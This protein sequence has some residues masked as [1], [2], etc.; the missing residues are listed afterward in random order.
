MENQN[1]IRVAIVYAYVPTYHIAAIRE[2]MKS[3]RIEYDLF[4]GIDAGA[5]KLKIFRSPGGPETKGIPF[6][7]LKN[8]WLTRNIL[9][10]SGVL[11][12]ACDHRY[13]AVIYAGNAYYISTWLAAFIGRIRGQQ[14]FMKTH[15]MSFYEEGVK[16]FV[17]G[18]FYGL[19]QG[20]LLYGHRAKKFLM[21]KRFDGGQLYVTYNC[22]DYA[23][24]QKVR[25]GLSDIDDMRLRASL[26]AEPARPLLIFIGRLTK[27]KRLDLLVQATSRLYQEGFFVNVVIIG[28]GEAKDS[29][30]HEVYSLGI[31]EHFK[32]LGE[33]YDEEE[34]GRWLHASDLCVSP[35]EV[36]LNV[37]HSFAY[38]TPV[39]THGDFSYQGPEAEAI[40]LNKTGAFF[41][42]GSAN[43]L[44]E[45]IS[46]WLRHSADRE[47]IRKQCIDTVER[48]YNPKKYA[49]IIAS[50]VLGEQIEGLEEEW[51]K[52]TE[53]N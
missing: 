42:R 23:A 40:E 19:S 49:Q 10:Q 22:L 8:Y 26:F 13:D 43:S 41:T 53:K 44:A 47:L 32:F 27:M 46:D 35:G 33:T 48:S 15:G 9:W 21:R 37:I 2:M 1:K 16:A 36:G 11:S 30:Y 28:D 31:Q 34:I 45:V 24:Q 7:V 18:C 6:K 38:G 5:V 52:I 14:V 3:S 20:L 12:I 17:R 29:L 25:S 50:A 51:F 39:I 4:A